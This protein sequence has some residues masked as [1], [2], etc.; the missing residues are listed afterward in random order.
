MSQKPFGS[1]QGRESERARPRTRKTFVEAHPKNPA[2]LRWSVLIACEGRTSS[3]QDQRDEEGD[4]ESW[5]LMRL[6]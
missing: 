1:T 5:L 3:N 2:F 6:D 4:Q